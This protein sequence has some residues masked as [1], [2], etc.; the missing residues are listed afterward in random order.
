MSGFAQAHDA[1]DVFRSGAARTLV[2]AAMK[3]RSQSSSLSH[4]KCANALRRVNL[5]AGDGKRVAPD[6]IHIYRDLAR[7]L[8]GVGVKTYS[9]FG[10]DFS[11]LFDRL[12]N[13]GLIV[14]H[15]D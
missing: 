8:H 1:G 7:S 12:H 13:S 4:K 10:R 5:V 2:A 9:C 14:R 3:K 6:A 11:N 15:H